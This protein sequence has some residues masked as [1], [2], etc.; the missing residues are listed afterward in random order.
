MAG[1]P[2]E[3][4]PVDPA[5]RRLERLAHLLDARWRVP[6][7]GWRFGLDGLAGLVP[8]LGD[9]AGGLV[10]AWLVLEA[11]RLGAPPGLVLRM[12]ANVGLDTLLGSVPLLG[13]LFD[14]VFK[15]NLR[16]L[17]LLRRHLEGRLPSRPA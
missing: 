6:G 12:A 8:G 13:S 15:A 10:A 3:G 1:P 9:L 11:R 17:R 16:N 7:T 5:L 2:P 14:F 4:P